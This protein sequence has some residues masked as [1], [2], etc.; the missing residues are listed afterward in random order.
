MIETLLDVKVTGD[1]AC[2]TRP[3]FKSERVSYPVMTPSAARGLLEAI[4]WKPEFRWEVREIH[5]LRPIKQLALLRN[6]IADRQGQEPF[7]VEGRRQQ[8]ASLILKDV[9][10]VVRAVIVLRPHATDPAAKYI[11]Q[12]RRRLERGQCHHT[13]YLGTR[14]FAASFEPPDTNEPIERFNLGIGPMLFDM[15]YRADERRPEMTFHRHDQGKPRIA[16]GYAQAHFFNA[17]VTEGILV[18]PREQYTRLYELEG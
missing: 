13:P 16:R 9:A 3:E 8:R 14:E 11:E 15:A 12:F 10:Y 6:E 5:M 1:Y 7:Q 18:I 2:F 17:N 4:F